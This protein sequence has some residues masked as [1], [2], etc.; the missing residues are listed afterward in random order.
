MKTKPVIDRI[1]TE[2]PLYKAAGFPTSLEPVDE[3]AATPAAF[4]HWDSEGSLPRNVIITSQK[5]TI[6]FAVLSVAQLISVDGLSEPIED[7]REQLIDKIVGWKPADN[8]E[9]ATHAGAEVIDIR[10]DMIWVKDYF[11]A[12]KYHRSTN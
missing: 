2:C 6:T 11:Q 4:A 8:L 10:G 1:K 7:A 9:P 5:R 12:T 3:M